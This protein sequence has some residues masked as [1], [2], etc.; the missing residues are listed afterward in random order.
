MTIDQI[1]GA[2]DHMEANYGLA[3]DADDY[4]LANAFLVKIDWLRDEL[5]RAIRAT[6]PHT[7][8]AD[9]RFFEGW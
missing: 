3:M 4:G 1:R 9:I 5:V 2:L 8:E 6:D 7:T